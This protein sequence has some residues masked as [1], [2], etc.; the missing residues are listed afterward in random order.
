MGVLFMVKVSIIMPVYNDANNLKKSINSVINQ[1]LTDIELI[2]VDDG[3]TDNSLD[4]LNKFA[5]SDKRIKVLSQKN[6]G[7]GKARNYGLKEAKGE[8]IAFLD[9][10][11][12][13][14]DKN[15]Y[16]KLYTESK[17]KNVIMASG[18]LQFD[19]K[20]DGI[21]T[22]FKCFKPIHELNLKKPHEY[23][24]P[25]YFYKNIFKRDFLIE[26]NIK[27]P[28][29]LRGQDPV[30][31]CEILV[32]I[33]KFLEVPVMYYCYHTPTVNKVDNF[34]KYY[35]YFVHYYEVFK[36]ICDKNFDRMVEEYSK[37]L[38]S[39]KDWDVHV[40]NKNEL[41]KL[42]EIMD[43]IYKV[44]I[45]Y[46]NENI[47][48]NIVSSFNEIINKINIKNLMII[49]NGNDKLPKN[50]S[51]IISLIDEPSSPKISVIIPVHNVEKYLSECLDSIINQTLKDIEIIC[52]NDESTDNSLEILNNYALKDSRIK[53]YSQKNQGL[54]GT[55][56][57]GM[58]YAKGKYIYFIDSDDILD[59]NALEKTYTICEEENLDMLIFKVINFHDD[60]GTQFTTD[61]FEMNF[62]KNMNGK[63]FNYKDI[64][65]DI[66]YM[67][68]V[69]YGQLFRGALIKDM[70]FPTGLI[71]EDN[72]FFIEAMLKSRR[73]SFLDEHL[74]FRRIR[75]NSITTTSDNKNFSDTLD[76]ANRI[77]DI[78]KK[79]GEYDNFL[80]TAITRKLGSGYD[81]FEQINIKYKQDFFNKLKKDFIT[82][83]KEFESVI[84]HLEPK[85]R[86]VYELAFTCNTCKEYQ[87]S[88]DLFRSELKLEEFEKKIRTDSELYQI[89]RVDLKNYGDETNSIEIIE[90]SDSNSKI[91]WPKW[92]NDEKGKGVVIES[93]YGVIDLKLMMIKN[94]KF[95]LSLRGHDSRDKHG[96]RQKILIDYTSLVINNVEYIENHELAW[97]DEPFIFNKSVKNSEILNIRI[98]W[99][100]KCNLESYVQIADSFNKKYQNMN[101]QNKNISSEFNMLK[102]EK[103]QLTNNL[104]NLQ[105]EKKQLC[106]KFDAICIENRKLIIRI[107]K[108]EN[109]N[110][111]NNEI[112]GLKI[113]NKKNNPLLSIFKK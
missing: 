35:D 82:R 107:D 108:L 72:P 51:D 101:Q 111:E 76:I 99:T 81:R 47:I 86:C 41:L 94:G 109:K 85:I 54:A 92:F 100:V 103:K 106:S 26:N 30:F 13:I 71:F 55:R 46:G 42:L 40:N 66:F 28:D 67:A 68:V 89:A 9:S 38:I 18:S 7:S 11:D 49:T 32:R 74:Y 102:N 39:L 6:Q 97:H 14:I 34:A 60:S 62:L 61:Y 110:K 70:E 1:T 63:I 78:T 44:F 4:V 48:K 112:H 75:P 43:K 3:S 64:G 93:T 8:Y 20:T 24:M 17:S 33:D 10:D 12:Y 95:E 79:Y 57:Q 73:V 25:W 52:I 104:N 77:I 56:N 21:F 88:V 27:F 105:N 31:F 16:Y 45:K 90:N 91:E 87:L 58:K 50:Y 69:A 53:I 113:K 83:K 59:L 19:S 5:K 98:T 36:L 15:A 84:P 37:T 29:L 22:E 96:N 65:E 2:C 23:C 80:K